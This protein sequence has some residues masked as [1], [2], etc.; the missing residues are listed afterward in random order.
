MTTPTYVA[1]KVGDH[2]DLV[3]QSTV[4][5]A[6]PSFWIFSGAALILFGLFRRSTGGLLLMI[7]GTALIYRGVAGPSQRPSS[8][9]QLRVADAVEEASLESFPASDAPSYTAS[10]LTP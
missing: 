1:K 5:A 7:A 10:S 3:P 4:P 6:P 9:R 8:G 2:Y